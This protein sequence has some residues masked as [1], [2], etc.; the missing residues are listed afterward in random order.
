MSVSVILTLY[1]F[2]PSIRYNGIKYQNMGFP[3]WYKTYPYG[4]QYHQLR[5]KILFL[6]TSTTF[7]INYTPPNNSDHSYKNLTPLFIMKQ[8]EF[9]HTNLPLEEIN[10]SSHIDNITHITYHDVP[11]K[12]YTREQLLPPP[13]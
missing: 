7:L 11:S 13:P 12:K 2:Y 6:A 5:S 4:P 10:S 3:L 8:I 1:N 9:G